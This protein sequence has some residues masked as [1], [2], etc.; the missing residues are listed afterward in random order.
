VN[1]ISEARISIFITSNFM[2][3][4]DVP[5]TVNIPSD[6]LTELTKYCLTKNIITVDGDGNI[7]PNFSDG[8]VALLRDV[9]SDETKALM[10]AGF[11]MQLRQGRLRSRVDESSP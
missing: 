2:T 8:I 1:P 6:L 4:N 3:V 5:V 10:N 11:V 7:E 9:Y